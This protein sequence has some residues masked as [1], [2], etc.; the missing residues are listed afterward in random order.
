MWAVSSVD[1]PFVSVSTDCG[2]IRGYRDELLGYGFLGVPYA[3]PPLPSP[4]NLRW[5]RSTLLGE[6]PGGASE[7]WSGPYFNATAPGPQCAQ[8]PSLASGGD[9]SYQGSEDCLTLDVWA[10]MSGG[11]GAGKPVLFYIHGGSLVE[12]NAPYFAGLAGEDL[13]IVAIRY[14]LNV[15]GFLALEALSDADPEGVSGNYG[16]SD[17]ITALRWVKK[18]IGAFG[19]DPGHVTIMG[20]SSGGTSVWNLLAA[21]SSFGL[22]VGAIPLS[23]A[24]RNNVT[25]AQAQRDNAV[26][27]NVTG[28]DSA[29][30][31]S[32]YACLQGLSMASVMA[33]FLYFQSSF[34]YW[35]HPDF[36]L[37]SPTEYQSG[38]AIV[39][40]VVIPVDLQQAFLDPSTHANV[41]VLAGSSAQEGATSRIPTNA[42]LAQYM[43]ALSDFVTAINGSQGGRVRLPATAVQDLADLYNA[44]LPEFRG[45]PKA[46]MDAMVADIRVVCGTNFNA[47]ALVQS[48]AA[49]AGAGTGG[50]P[51][52]SV[53]VWHAYSD[54]SATSTIHCGHCYQFNTLTQAACTPG[55]HTFPCNDTDLAFHANMKAVV[56][57]FVAHGS[58][59]PP[60]KRLGDT[61]D[62]PASQ[63]YALSEVGAQLSSTN[64]RLKRR[65]EFWRDTGILA[66]YAWDE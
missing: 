64:D 15:L 58:L 22:Y 10:P 56:V 25:M 66:A 1:P 38:L 3:T 2:V 13:V 18:N 50:R 4:Y 62:S 52:A 35:S 23:S 34:P 21:P 39:D 45:L 8:R 17:Q 7:C 60:L 20:C 65:C 12:G 26:F 46:S 55:G 16:F 31:P 43:T 27:Y 5:K 36:E 28:C 54:L 11:G 19:G 61:A 44:S 24:S 49:G 40:G 59:P 32:R 53:D 42:T 47:L 6:G 29:P 51:P 9:V 37:P 57:G 63:H 14:R 30:S 48:G 41:P 33:G